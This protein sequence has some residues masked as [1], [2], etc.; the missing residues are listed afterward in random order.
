MVSGAGE[1]LLG[2]FRVLGTASRYVS[3]R[4]G[5]PGH[6]RTLPFGDPPCGTYAIGSSLPPGTIHPRRP[7]RFGKV[8]ALVL[9]PTGGEALEAV[10][11][12]R[13]RVVLHG[14]PRDH[15]RR[16][17]RTR[18]GLRAGNRNLV[19]LF[20]AI[21]RAQAA[22]DPLSIVEVVDVEAGFPYERALPPAH[23]RRDRRGKRA[24]KGVSHP[25]A[26][27][28]QQSSGAGIAIAAMAMFGVT[29]AS[30]TRRG[31]LATALLAV[32]GSKMLA[33]CDDE[34]DACVRECEGEYGETGSGSAIAHRSGPGS[35]SGSGS[36]SSSDS[37][38]SCIEVCEEDYGT[39]GGVG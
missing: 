4:R 37:V 6:D 33:A 3:A 19:A 1:V 10:A 38:E 17:R 31:F 13:A 39:G 25:R 7:G 2:P 34:P 28:P 18:G 27:A 5:N 32:A 14:G 15:H 20:A 12:G 24:P 22:G 21:N 29:R 11:R 36:G 23:R 26:A 16:L 8:G 9:T 30:M 35:G